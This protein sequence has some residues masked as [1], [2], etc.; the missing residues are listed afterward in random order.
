MDVFLEI[1]EQI[2]SPWFGVNFDPSN[3]VLAG[4]DPIELLKRIKHRVVSMHASDRY[5]TSGTLEDLRKEENE[6]GYANRLAH[7]VI[8]KGINDYD[9]IFTILSEAGFNSWIS[10]EDGMD[11][12]DGLR[13]SVHFLKSKIERYFSVNHRLPQA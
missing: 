11:G 10:I 7:G 3:T 5:L 6:I 13:D 9:V 12:M 2:D 4:E 1:V 8:G